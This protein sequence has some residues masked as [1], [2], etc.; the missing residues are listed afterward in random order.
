[1]TMCTLL[2]VNAAMKPLKLVRC[3]QTKTKCMNNI[4]QIVDNSYFKNINTDTLMHV[5][6][7]TLSPLNETSIVK[8]TTEFDG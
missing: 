5:W 1:M 4:M 7:L 3:V 6:R 8:G 2:S